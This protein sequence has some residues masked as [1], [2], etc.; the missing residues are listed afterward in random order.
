MKKEN[1]IVFNYNMAN[2]IADLPNNTPTDIPGTSVLLPPGSYKYTACISLFCDRGAADGTTETMEGYA[3]LGSVQIQYKV[4][5]LV[6][7]GQADV[8]AEVVLLGKF[9]LL[10][11][12]IFKLQGAI[13]LTGTVSHRNITSATLII[14]KVN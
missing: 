12:T 1:N 9:V 7:S 8:E 4:F 3:Y 6:V 14:E 2:P 10:T 13:A 5:Q 11:S